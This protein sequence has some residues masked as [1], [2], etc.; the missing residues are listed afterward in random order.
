MIADTEKYGSEYEIVAIDMSKAFDCIDRK[1]LIN[2]LKGIVAP[3]EYQMIRYI[4]S[5]TCLTARIG[6]E[7]GERFGTTIGV[8][9]GDALSPILFTIYLEAAMRE[10]RNENPV[11]SQQESFNQDILYADDTDFVTQIRDQ[12]QN[13]AQTVQKLSEVLQRWNLKVNT[14]K[15][16]YIQINRRNIKDIAV[17]KLGNLISSEKDIPYRIAFADSVFRNLSRLWRN[18]HDITTQTKVNMY[19]S[20]IIP[21]MT[22]NIGANGAGD[23]SIQAFDKAQRRHLRYICGKTYLDMVSNVELYNITETKPISIM[24]AEQ[25]WNL[26]KRVAKMEN[27][28]PAKRIMWKYFNT[29][30]NKRV[31]KGGP[32]LTLHTSLCRD[33]KLIEMKFKTVNDYVNVTSAL[34]SESKNKNVIC[35][36]ILSKKLRKYEH[37]YIPKEAIPNDPGLPAAIQLERDEETSTEQRS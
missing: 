3:S 25:R 31:G 37:I 11:Q 19:K 6:G 18:H 1:K 27:T 8:P 13:N 14:D 36:Q 16:E 7:Y 2:V 4:L 26:F 10:F 24:A 5:D 20:C 22:Y 29:N 34:I 9:Q 35:D 21:I 23:L 33:L 12:Q 15:T 17:R 28:T 30:N 32:R